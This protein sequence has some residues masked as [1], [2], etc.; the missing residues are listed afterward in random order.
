[1]QAIQNHT[2][3]HV[4]EP[5]QE[6]PIR[7]RLATAR[8]HRGD[9]SRGI[10]GGA[11]IGAAAGVLF[12][13]RIYAALRSLRRQL[14]DAAADA[15]GA[16]VKA[17]QEATIRVGDAVDDLQQ[18]GRGVQDNLLSVVVRGAEDVK[19]RAIAAQTELDQRGHAARRPS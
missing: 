3:G 6:I 1:L 4:T 7:P 14:T 17:Y 13:P 18:K 15:S 16:A 10:V 9:F 2:G 12:A 8:S 5:R 11:L 19:E